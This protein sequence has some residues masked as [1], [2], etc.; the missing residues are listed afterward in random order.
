MI[1]CPFCQK[2]FSAKEAKIR[3][4]EENNY[5]W[6][7][8]IEILSSEIGYPKDEMHEIL[9]AL[10][11]Q[12]TKYL[13]THDGVVEAK[14]SKSTSELTIAEFED[15]LTKIREWAIME[16]GILIPLPNEKDNDEHYRI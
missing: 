1:K 12:E 8:V 13:K 16:F 7:V 5:Y 2:E 6:G 14:I 3:S 15:Y 4:T 9:K 11:L 10:F